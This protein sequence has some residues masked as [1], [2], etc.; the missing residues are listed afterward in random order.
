MLSERLKDTIHYELIPEIQKLEKENELL[1]IAR[2]NYKEGVDIYKKQQSE[3]VE[4]IKLSIAENRLKDFN[5]RD[6]FIK[7]LEKILNKKWEEIR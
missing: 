3:L 2:D 1:K 5:T 6:A 7:L 4:A